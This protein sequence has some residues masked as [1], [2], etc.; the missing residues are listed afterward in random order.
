MIKNLWLK[1]KHGNYS[2]NQVACPFEGFSWP[3]FL[4]IRPSLCLFLFLY[5]LISLSFSLSIV[6][7]S[8]LSEHY[9]VNWSASLIAYWIKNLWLKKK[10]GNYSY[11]Q[12]ACPFEG[13]SWPFF[14]PIRPSL[15]LFL[16]LYS[17][18]SLSFSLSIVGSSHLSEHYFVNWSASLIAYWIRL[19]AYYSGGRIKLHFYYLDMLYHHRYIQICRRTETIP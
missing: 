4:P 14:L 3:F 13:F 15:C 9:F 5:S 12:V 18:I 8:H 1:K 2:Y 11:N 19:T 7:S 16:F 10:H 6:G 17:L